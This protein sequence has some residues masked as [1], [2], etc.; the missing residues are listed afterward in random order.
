MGY[1]NAG[2][3]VEGVDNWRQHHYPFTF[4]MGDAMKYEIGPDDGFDAYHAS[5]PCQAYIDLNKNRPNFHPRL[6]DPIRQRLLATGKPFIIENV[7]EAPINITTLLCGT[8]FGLPFIRH[9]G[10]EI[11]LPGDDSS[12]ALSLARSMFKYPLPCNHWGT[13]ADGDFASVSNSNPHGRTRI[14]DGVKVTPKRTL[15]EKMVAVRDIDAMQVPWMSRRERSQAIPP[16]YTEFL[17]RKLIAWM[18][19][20][21]RG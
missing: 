16:V 17:G 19:E 1:H 9:R 14:V 3:D 20:V 7:P 8:M 6:I 13:V 5:P 21:A 10:F 11:Y 4:H 18:D 2:F 12:L 15:E